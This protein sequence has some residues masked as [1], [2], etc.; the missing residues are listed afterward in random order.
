MSQ[1]F[2]ATQTLLEGNLGSISLANLVQ[3]IGLEQKSARLTLRRVEIG[4]EAELLFRRGELVDAEVNGMRGNEAVIRIVNWWNAGTFKLVA[5]NPFEEPEKTVTSRMDF[6]LLESMRQLDEAGYVREFLPNLTS[7]A[8][9]TQS[10]LDAFRWDVSDPAEW[11]PHAIRQ[12]PRSFSMAQLLA[13]MPAPESEISDLLKMLLATQAIRVHPPADGGMPGAP[14][15]EAFSPAPGA[16]MEA[17]N[18]RYES[19]AQLLMEYVGFEQAYGLVDQTLYDL[20][21][22]DLDGLTMSQLLDLCDRMSGSLSQHL[23][24]KKQHEAAR[25][26]RARATSLL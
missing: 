5:L 19:F 8:S 7:A 21:F 20:G 2:T 9:F 26:L 1:A 13:V 15:A 25:R 6:L 22:E 17:P 10:A 3:L 14:E 11:L 24:R 23:D 4:Q 16:P 18:S 12:L